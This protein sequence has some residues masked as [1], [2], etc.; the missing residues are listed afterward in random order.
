MLERKRSYEI[1]AKERERQTRKDNKGRILRKGEG[2][3]KDGRYYYVYTDISGKRRRIYGTNLIELREAEQTIKK[4]IADGI[5]VAAAHRT[6][7]EQFELYLNTKDIRQSSQAHYRELWN[8]CVKDDIGK[9]KVTDIKKVDLQMFY[10]KLA[11]KGYADSTIRQYGI[12]MIMPVMEMALDNDIIR[13]NPARGCMKE[14]NT[15]NKKKESLTAAEQQA[16]IEY[17]RQSRRYNVYLPLFTVMFSTACRRGEIIGLT[18]NDINFKNKTISINHQLLYKNYGE[19]FNFYYSEPK[20]E[21]GH[22]II[23]M[24]PNCYKA[25]IKQREQQLVLGIDKSIEVAGLNNFVFTTLSGT[26]YAPSNI[27]NL[28]K[29]IVTQYNEHE[30]VQAK[31]QKR[32]PKLLPPI[33]CHSFRHTGCTRLAEA[34]MDIKTLQEYMGHSDIKVTMNVYNH[35]DNERMTKEVIKAASQSDVI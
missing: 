3:N 13:K 35:V 23:P 7:N 15:K 34:H 20:T 4:D 18:W 26:P 2:Q 17:V 24:T 5:D 21:A 10:K 8:R 27:N 32:V 33:S 25:L 31:A 9:R 30:M 1:M 16:F 29:A 12:S 6:L 28:L 11:D 14:Y 19:G 22:R